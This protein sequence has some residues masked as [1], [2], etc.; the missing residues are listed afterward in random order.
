MKYLTLKL[1]FRFAFVFI[2]A[3]NSVFAETP[4][5]TGTPVTDAPR[6]LQWEYDQGTHTPNL[7]AE[8]S[9]TLLDFHGS[10][11]SC[12]LL[13][14]TEG[15]YHM[16]LKDIWP[17]YL[18]KFKEPLKNAFYS[19]S[20]PVTVTQI[21]N[22]VLQFGN[23]YAKCAP[24][25]AVANKQVIDKLVSMDATE[26][27]AYPIYKDR[28]QVLLVKRGNPKNIK[29]IWDLARSDINLITP[30]T[31]LE[32][33]AF[34]TYSD[35]IFNIALHDSAPPVSINADQLFQQV[36]NG[37]SGNP[38]K[39]LQGSRIHHRDE[40]WSVAYGKADVAVIYYHLGIL[41]KQAFPDTFDI[42][43]LGGTI[44]NPVPL[45]GSNIGERYVVALKGNWNKRQ[46][47]AREILISTLRSNEFS[48]ILEKRGLQRPLGFVATNDNDINI[49][50]SQQDT[51]PLSNIA[52]LK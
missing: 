21:S 9:N 44:D 4:A 36:F 50:I 7:N 17:V 39:W 52:Y 31:K 19:T 38:N 32:S 14:S 37:E 29:T 51:Q 12:D 40:P 8:T 16:A 1:D 41:A 34:K 5:I 35:A 43:S 28:G 49:K 45:A 24:S 26:G 6:I 30:N 10:L 3:C 18:S 33:G 11:D 47:E 48:H 2:I 22:S 20:P 13:L 46:F 42:I 27:I 15:N 23:L 25:V